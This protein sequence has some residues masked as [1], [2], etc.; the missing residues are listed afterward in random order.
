M[1]NGNPAAD[2]DPTKSRRTGVN[3]AG[4]TRSEYALRTNMEPP[5]SRLRGRQLIDELGELCGGGALG[6][7]HVVAT[8]RGAGAEALFEAHAQDPA[9]AVAGVEVIAGAGADLR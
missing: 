9:D 6:G 7:A 3:E 2:R 5:T 8:G 4:P 1:R